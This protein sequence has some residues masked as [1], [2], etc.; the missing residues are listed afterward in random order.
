MRPCPLA[1]APAP[2]ETHSA[3]PRDIGLWRV[4]GAYYCSA[5]AWEDIRYVFI[6][7]TFSLFK[8]NYVLSPFFII[9]D[10]E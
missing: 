9:N 8:F 4:I 5:I 10:K 3:A 6:L 2:D 1:R 7:L